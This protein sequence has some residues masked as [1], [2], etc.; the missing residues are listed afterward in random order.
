MARQSLNQIIRERVAEP[1]PGVAGGR[2]TA[3]ELAD[4]KAAARKLGLQMSSF[5][6][7]AVVAA[8]A[9]VRGEDRA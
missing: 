4:A 3:A 5:V 2:L 9:E 1:R 7:V 6:R 8:T